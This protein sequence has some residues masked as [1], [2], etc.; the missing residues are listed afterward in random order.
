M[1]PSKSDRPSVQTFADHEIIVPPNKLSRVISKVS[2]ADDDPV[3]RAETALAAL[4]SE[5]GGWMIDECERLD[6][7]RRDAIAHGLGSAYREVL[8]RVAHDIKGSAATFGFPLVAPAAQ[9]LCRVLEH[10][11]DPARIPP[12]LVGQHVDAIR[13]IVREYARPDIGDIATALNRKL[14]NV[15]YEFLHEENRH[16]PNYLKTVFESPAAIF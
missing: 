16:R 2:L 8:F 12:N 4:S 5:F 11:P 14:H 3:R 1:P 13:A 15:T 7:A 9:S 10:T 6:A